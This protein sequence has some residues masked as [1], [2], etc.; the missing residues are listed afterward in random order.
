MQTALQS[1]ALGDPLEPLW[2][3]EE[4]RKHVEIE[5]N[6]DD[7][8]LEGLAAAAAAHLTG[9]DTIWQRVWVSQAWRDFRVAFCDAIPLRLDPVLSVDRL[10]YL[11]QD[12][13]ERDVPA[14]DYYLVRMLT[15]A[16]IV[17]RSG[18]DWPNDVA[19]RLDAVR[20]DYTA[21]Y[22]PSRADVPA[23]V[24]QALRFLVGHWYRHREAVVIGGEPRKV[25]HTVDYLM[26]P[27][28]RFGLA[29]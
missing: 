10:W 19:D 11:A 2:R 23:H 15:G 18:H 21:G 29:S 12:G 4:L 25:P 28:R 14:E 24:G 8:Y 5:H 1:L 3:L 6:E 7:A 22:G 16:R 9:V 13:S 20:V 17:L 27:S 26:M